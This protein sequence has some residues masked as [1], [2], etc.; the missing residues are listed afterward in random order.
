MAVITDDEM[1]LLTKNVTQAQRDYAAENMGGS[2][3]FESFLAGAQS[4]D[5]HAISSD[6]WW[7]ILLERTPVEP[8]PQYE[9]QSN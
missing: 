7:R 6:G 2:N 5:A 8:H 4:V 1:K 9:N 3:Y